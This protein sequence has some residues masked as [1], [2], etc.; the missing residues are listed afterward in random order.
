MD[1][2]SSPSSWSIS[3]G[4]SNRPLS[5]VSTLGRGV[6]NRKSTFEPAGKQSSPTK[7]PRCLPL[8]S[9]SNLPEVSQVKVLRRVSRSVGSFNAPPPLSSFG[10]PP[11]FFS[12]RTPD[13]NLFSLDQA[14]NSPSMVSSPLGFGRGRGVFQSLEQQNPIGRGRGVG[15]GTPT[16]RSVSTF[17][18][19]SLINLKFN[20]R[21]NVFLWR[22][23]RE[24]R[25]VLLALEPQSLVT[26]QATAPTA[27][28][29]HWF[30]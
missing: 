27:W 20:S 10:S 26:R 7:E 3:T 11:T 29:P 15:S 9:E 5:K 28:P 30:I 19:S 14:S 1:R 21:R 17:A 8:R 4:T 23:S 25:S 24:S 2:P 22:R 13:V 18:L 6:P 16:Q 12:P